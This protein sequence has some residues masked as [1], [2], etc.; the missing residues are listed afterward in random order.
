VFEQRR[1]ESVP[2][3]GALPSVPRSQEVDETVITT[4]SGL[5][6]ADIEE[7]PVGVEGTKFR[8]TA[9]CPDGT[10]QFK[11]VKLMFD[12]EEGVD[13]RTRLSHLK[14]MGINVPHEVELH[15]LVDGTPA[16]V[17]TDLSEGGKKLVLSA[18]NPELYTPEV[19]SSIRSIPEDVKA[20]MNEKLISWACKAGDGIQSL[21]GTQYLVAPN[22]FALVIDPSE[23]R[24][25]DIY[26]ID[27]GADLTDG[28][29]GKELRYLNVLSVG[30]FF[31][32][33]LGE[34]LSLSEED[35]RL[36][37]L[38]VTALESDNEETRE[39]FWDR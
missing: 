34:R 26:A 3:E 23:P 8:A 12:A 7:I 5:I 4:S 32:M 10:E 1:V 2:V 39:A 19:R 6:F 14:E 27:V 31:A 37:S 13:Q 20:S 9:V 17:M 33:V 15:V 35:P 28:S 22:V 18:N 30:R 25:A 29:G 36:S 11:F 38:D 21:E 16:L 24:D